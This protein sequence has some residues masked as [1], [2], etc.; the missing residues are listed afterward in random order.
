MA[1]CQPEPKHLAAAGP[2]YGLEHGAYL[3]TQALEAMA[4]GDRMG[5]R[6]VHHRQ[7][8]GSSAASRNPT[9]SRFWPRAG[10]WRFHAMGGVSG[11][12][13][14]AGAYA[15]FPWRRQPGRIPSPVRG[16]GSGCGKAALDKGISPS[17]S[18]F[19]RLRKSET[20]PAP[21]WGL[22]EH[23]E[24]PLQIRALLDITSPEAHVLGA[25]RRVI[26]VKFGTQKPRG[27]GASGEAAP[28]GP[29]PARPGGGLPRSP[30]VGKKPPLPGGLA[31]GLE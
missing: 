15:V 12:G 10:A 11:P 24:Y 29:A 13:S 23:A 26:H 28:S 21:Q 14:D 7:P 20:G 25:G 31:R 9:W 4:A 17:D 3:S 22:A 30:G 5:A 19:S 27:N 2:A 16:P 18:G 1:H 6:P 8:A